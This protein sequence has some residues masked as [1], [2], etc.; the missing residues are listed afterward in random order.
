[1]CKG[2]GQVLYNNG[3]LISDRACRCDYTKGYKFIKQP[4]KKCFCIPSEED[5]S[6][7]LDK[8]AVDLTLSPGMYT[9]DVNRYSSVHR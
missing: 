8:C 6:C 5:C 2:E 9:A 4:E 1:M 3:T 7:Y